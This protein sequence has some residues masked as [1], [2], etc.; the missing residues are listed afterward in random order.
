MINPAIKQ[1]IDIHLSFLVKN[2][3][4]A[5][6]KNDTNSKQL[7]INQQKLRG[8][9]EILGLKLST[10]AILAGILP[11]FSNLVAAILIFVIGKWVATKVV[12]MVEAIGVRSKIDKTL[13]SFLGNMLFGLMMALIVLTALNKLGVNTSSALAILGGAALAIG[14]ALQSELSS[15]AA[16]FMIILFRPFNLDDYVEIDGREGTV[17]EIN[18]MATKLLTLDNHLVIIPNRNIT[19][20]PIINYTMQK[21]RRVNQIIGIGYGADIR[22][23]RE[24][25][26]KQILAH[27]KVL[28]TPEPMVKV[29]NLGD[30]AVDMNVL[31][32]VNSDDWLATKLDLIEAIKIALDDANIEIP[33]PQRSVHVSGLS[34]VVKNISKEEA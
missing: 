27:P 10:E 28:K 23:A 21:T 34:D 20:H 13:M 19:S 30:N 15:L 24:I 8:S 16:G 22:E 14:M 31:A 12:M 2:A 11:F 3:N 26:M 9:M 1:I 5:F 18:I 6:V 32:W 17:T 4:I 25:M 29:A 7:I 33:F